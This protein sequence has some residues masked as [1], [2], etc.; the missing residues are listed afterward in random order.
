MKKASD[1]SKKAD[2]ALV[3]GSSLRVKPACWFTEYCY[4]FGNDGKIVICNLQIT[5]YEPKSYLSIFSETDII[6][7][8]VMKKL[9]IDI[10]SYDNL[11]DPTELLKLNPQKLDSPDIQIPPEDVRVGVAVTVSTTC[12]HVESCIDVQN[13]A[14]IGNFIPGAACNTCQYPN[15]IWYCVTCAAISC[16]RHVKGHA[17]DHFKSTGHS[18][19]ISFEDLSCWCYTC[20]DYI[21]HKALDPGVFAL[22]MKKFRVPHPKQL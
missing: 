18:I 20:N 6:M 12:N 1:W 10:P 11:N 17:L 15:E 4:S 3:L 2:L 22:H 13:L 19:A 8:N 9:G 16:G 7:A 21:E 5:D 14:N